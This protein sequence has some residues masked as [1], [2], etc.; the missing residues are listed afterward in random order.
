M[1]K[2]KILLVGFILVALVQL[3]IPAQMI[4][5]REKVLKA[6]IEYKFRTA[7]VDPNDPFRGKYITLRFKDDQVDVQ[8]K[9]DWAYGEKIYVL[10]KTDKEGYA[11][12][13]YISKQQPADSED[14][15]VSKVL[16]VS[17]DTLNQV[18]V[19]FPFNRFYMEESKAPDAEIAYRESVRD[20]SLV[21]YAL[22][23]IREGD[24]VLKDVLIDGVSIKEIV[25]DVQ[26]MKE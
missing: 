13:D 8:N 7:P 21:T 22:V 5:N 17:S 11:V 18:R 23:N 10:L 4:L 19:Q 15:F 2:K 26:E 6:G 20:T 14:F 1:D 25:K 3:F 16:S 12:I 9:S 24:A